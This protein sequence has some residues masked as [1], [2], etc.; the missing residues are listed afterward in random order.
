HTSFSRDWSSDVC[1]S[2]LVEIH[3]YAIFDYAAVRDIVD[4]LGGIT[5]DIK[6]PDERGI[7]DPNFQPQEGGPLQ[8]PNGPQKI[9][10]QTALRL[11]SEERRV[12]KE[13]SEGI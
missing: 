4:A 10:G 9:D 13:F 7:Y 5:V 3:N 6:S 12:G 1:S 8:L 2:D 11:R